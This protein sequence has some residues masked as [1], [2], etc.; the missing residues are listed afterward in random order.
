MQEYAKPLPIPNEDTKEFWEGCKRHELLIQRCP[1]CHIY[2]FY[3]SSLC[4]KCMSAQAEWA[5]VSGRGH[6]YSYAI[7]RHVRSPA[8]A[9]AVPYILGIIELEEGVRMMSN[10]VECKP[11]EAWIGMPVEVVF[12]DV[13]PEI[14]LPKFRP[15]KE[16]ASG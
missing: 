4:P 1:E 15:R 9:D 14:T 2:R 11:E 7:G 13:T 8:W 10:V 5:R 6:I 12:E 16:G 3:P